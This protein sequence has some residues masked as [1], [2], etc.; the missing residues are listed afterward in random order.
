MISERDFNNSGVMA[1]DNSGV[2]E[3]KPKKKYKLDRA[4]EENTKPKSKSRVKTK[5]T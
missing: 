3:Q 2:F 1:E 5:A 4:N